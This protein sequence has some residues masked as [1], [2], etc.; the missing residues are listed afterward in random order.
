MDAEFLEL[1]FTDEP[2][3]EAKLQSVEEIEQNFDKWLES[4]RQ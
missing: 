1:P 2:F 3:D 4:L